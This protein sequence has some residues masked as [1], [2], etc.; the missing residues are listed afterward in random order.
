MATE[1]DAIIDALAAKLNTGKS[2]VQ[3]V[4]TEFESLDT[5]EKQ[6]RKD[7]SIFPKAIVYPGGSET[8]QTASTGGSEALG[9]VAFYRLP[10]GV[11]IIIKVG[12]D[13]Q[14]EREAALKEMRDLIEVRGA[15]ITP[16]RHRIVL[17]FTSVERLIIYTPSNK[18][19]LVLA[20]AT[21]NFAVDYKYVI[22]DS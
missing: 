19:E 21:L 14:T 17:P 15:T 5:L 7:S 6:A 18:R 4:T 16:E 11:D 8:P 3:T 20:F 1:A 13:A 12:S 10:V 9:N 2:I 22:G